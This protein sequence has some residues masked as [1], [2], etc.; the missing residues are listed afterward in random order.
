[1]ISGPSQPVLCLNR[2]KLRF[3][4]SNL[5]D[6]SHVVC[7]THGE[8]QTW[9]AGHTCWWPEPWWAGRCR[10]TLRGPQPPKPAKPTRFTFT[11]VDLMMSSVCPNQ[12]ICLVS[13]VKSVGTNWK[14]HSFS[15]SMINRIYLSYVLKAMQP[16][17]ITEQKAKQ[18]NQQK[19]ASWCPAWG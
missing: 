11:T 12:D 3:S 13:L 5:N 17:N 1:M 16:T 14:C 18:G 9:T 4:I 10:R 19:W 15:P 2:V 8:S 6:F 7:F